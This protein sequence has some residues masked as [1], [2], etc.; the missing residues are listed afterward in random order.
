MVH[1][2]TIF[3]MNINRIHPERGTLNVSPF[4]KKRQQHEVV[5]SCC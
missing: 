3:S 4:L 1:A 2:K 5:S